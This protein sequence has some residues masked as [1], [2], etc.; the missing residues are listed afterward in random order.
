[1]SFV[2]EWDNDEHTVIRTTYGDP[3]TWEEAFAAQHEFNKMADTTVSAVSSIIDLS[4]L[5][6]LPPNAISN[7]QNLIARA[8]PRTDYTILVGMNLF[9]RTMENTVGKLYRT[10]VGQKQNNSMFAK[11]LEDA[12]NQLQRLHRSPPRV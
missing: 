8:Y 4:H 6:K 1:M 10:V 3:L 5:N 2:V 9:V 12:R 11:D 7:I